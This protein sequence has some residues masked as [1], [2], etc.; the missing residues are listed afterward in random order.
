MAA[1]TQAPVASESRLTEKE[2]WTRVVEQWWAAF[3]KAITQAN[4]EALASYDAQSWPSLTRARVVQVLDNVD[5][6]VVEA[7]GSLVWKE[8]SW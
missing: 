5:D 4:E 6:K 3:S 2:R 1:S 8:Q 7:A